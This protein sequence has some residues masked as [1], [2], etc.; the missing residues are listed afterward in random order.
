[1]LVAVALA[2]KIHSHTRAGQ[3]EH[4]A[5][6][7]EVEQL[8]AELAEAGDFTPGVAVQAFAADVR[9]GSFPAAAESY[10]LSAEQ[11]EQLGLYGRPT[12]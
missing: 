7:A 2:T 6:L 1:M 4:E 9:G 11:A 8:R 3:P 12:D 10:H 5:F